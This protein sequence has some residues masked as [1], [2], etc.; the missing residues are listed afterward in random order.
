MLLLFWWQWTTRWHQAWSKAFEFLTI[1]EKWVMVHL[2]DKI[3]LFHCFV[4]AEQSVGGN[5]R[6]HGQWTYQ[7]RCPYHISASL[8][9]MASTNVAFE[10][11]SHIWRPLKSVVGCTLA[12]QTPCKSYQGHCCEHTVMLPLTYGEP[13]VSLRSK[14]LVRP[15]HL[16]C[17]P[18]P[19]WFLLP[20]RTFLQIC[21]SS[22]KIQTK[23]V[24]VKSKE[25]LL[26]IQ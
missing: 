7:N 26:K 14:A 9:F 5:N 15:T 24:V 25:Y 3:F 16:G 8:S 19:V 20:A 6:H 4:E 21:P 12:L 13:C 2:H 17:V 18:A 10:E 1:C 11:T 23:F 22:V